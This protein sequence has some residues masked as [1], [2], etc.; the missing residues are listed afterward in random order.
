MAN[1]RWMPINIEQTA[2]GKMMQWKQAKSVQNY[3]NQ[4]QSFSQSVSI[5]NVSETT[6][7]EMFINGLKTN[8]QPLVRI[9][10][11]KSLQDA[12]KMA[13]KTDTSF[14]SAIHS[15]NPNQY[16]TRNQFSFHKP[17]H[18]R[19]TNHQ[20]GSKDDPIVFNNVETDQQSEGSE[21]LNAIDWKNSVVCYY[22]KTKGHIIKDCKKRIQKEA[23]T[24][25]QSKNYSPSDFDL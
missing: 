4:F 22:C 15:N 25:Q 23:M 17:Y 3:I 18:N 19:N 1:T 7:V 13:L 20:S 10:E 12:Y 8:I 6:R 11:P 9:N 24:Q 21:D 16:Q 14:V 2:L 5:E